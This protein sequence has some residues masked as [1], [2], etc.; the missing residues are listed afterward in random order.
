MRSQPLI[1]FRVASNNAVPAVRN[2]AVVGLK[3]LSCQVRIGFRDIFCSCGKRM[4]LM[5]IIN[6]IAAGNGI[7]DEFN[8]M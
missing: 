8:R 1:I 3:L 2:H 5:L 6:A 4:Q 7:A